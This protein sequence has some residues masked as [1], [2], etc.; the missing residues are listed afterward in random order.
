MNPDVPRPPGTLVIFGGWFFS[1]VVAETAELLGWTIAGFVDPDPPGW[2]TPLRH[3]PD[4]SFAIVAIGNNPQRA[5]VHGKVLER[6]RRVVSIIHPTASVSQSAVLEKGCYLAE[7]VTVRS[8]AVVGSGTILN[9]GSVVSHDCQIGPFVTFGPNAATSG[10]VS[11]GARTTLGVGA[12]VRPHAK[13]GCDCE[14]GAGAAVACDIRD[15]STVVGVPA[16][17]IPKRSAKQ[18]KQSDWSANPIW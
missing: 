6:G 5:F 18:D 2:V 7:Y 10:H 9:S 12:C 15:G 14:V 13:I 4:E 11:I 17:A 3:V 16:R 8:A 1:R